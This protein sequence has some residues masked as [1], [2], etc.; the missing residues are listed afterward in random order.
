MKKML[1]DKISMLTTAWDKWDTGVMLDQG[2][3]SEDVE[4][5][6]IAEELFLDSADELAV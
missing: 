5:Q 3:I 2:I 4:A 6:L 1:Q